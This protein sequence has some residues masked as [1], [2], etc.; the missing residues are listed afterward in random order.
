[1]WDWLKRL[2]KVSFGTII[3]MLILYAISGSSIMS[4]G[5][6]IM[7]G[8]IVWFAWECHCWEKQREKAM[9]L[10]RKAQLEALS[11]VQREIITREIVKVKCAYCGMLVESTL[12]QCPNCN[13][14]MK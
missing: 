10:A 1:M 6:P 7:F 14:I 4:V 5:I 3:A 2:L 8:M 9:E 12:S 13:G 11:T